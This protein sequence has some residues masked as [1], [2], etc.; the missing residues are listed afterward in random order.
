MLEFS[1]GDLPQALLVKVREENVD[2]VLLKGLE[3]G[4]DNLVELDDIQGIIL[5]HVGPLKHLLSGQLPRGYGQLELVQDVIKVD[6]LEGDGELLE[7]HGV[8]LVYVHSLEILDYL[9]L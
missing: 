3:G 2:F 7:G 8:A 6:L 4:G 9:S 1:E 5:V